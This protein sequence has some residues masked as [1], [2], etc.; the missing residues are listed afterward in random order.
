[1]EIEPPWFGALNNDYLDYGTLYGIEI[2][3]E[4]GS[5]LLKCFKMQALAIPLLV[6]E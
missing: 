4:S 3:R 2:R 5:L 6:M 1:M